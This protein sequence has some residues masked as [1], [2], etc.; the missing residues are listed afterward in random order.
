[1]SQITDIAKQFIQTD[2]SIK[3]EPIGSGL[4]NDT[5]LVS[6]AQH[7]FVLQK[8]NRQ[9]FPEPARI[10]ENLMVFNQ[11]LAKKQPQSVKLRIPELL[12]TI[13]QHSYV[14]DQSGQF[15]RAISYIE[16]SISIER[17]ENSAQAQQIGFALG[18]FHDLTS[19]LKPSLMQDTLPEFHIAPHYLAQY[20]HVIDLQKMPKASAEYEFCKN[21]IAKNKAITNTLEQ[22][23]Q[24]GL[25]STKIIHGD[26]KLN[27]F[28]FNRQGNKVISLIDLDTVKPGL[29]HYDLGDCL[30][31]CCQQA[32]P[33]RFDMDIAELILS[34]Y[35]T[36]AGQFF[37][38]QDYDYLYAA[39]R[40]IPFELGLRFFT[41]YLSGN[42]YFKVIEP[43]QNLYRA[44]DQFL[45]SENIKQ[46]E[47]FFYQLL[48]KIV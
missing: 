26:P 2:D 22:A 16:N 17:L 28:L 44:K 8:I 27:N 36:E 34:S 5:Y 7:H 33:V 45:L 4:I 30:R 37:T 24:Q 25:L 6:T 47:K 3:I 32:A 1:M 29:V 19:D 42:R 18:H 20:Q 12:L 13:D 9:V 35:L 43:E 38:Q 40:L 48:E 39:I 10:M 21:Y 11:H 23:K 31:S 41:D 46:Q 14:I 15:W